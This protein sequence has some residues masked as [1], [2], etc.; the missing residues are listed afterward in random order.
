MASSEINLVMFCNLGF[1][2]FF[3]FFSKKRISCG[4]YNY[5]DDLALLA[6]TPTQAESLQH[7]LEQAARGIGLYMN[8]DKTEFMHFN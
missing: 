1:T 3:A 2:L 7:S 6:N 4:N 5:V 8:S